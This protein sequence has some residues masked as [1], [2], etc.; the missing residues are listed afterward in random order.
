MGAVLVAAASA[1]QLAVALVE[2]AA[3]AL[4]HWRWNSSFAIFDHTLQHS[5]ILAAL[6]AWQDSVEG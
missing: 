5:V 6:V 1:T 4:R 2:A 3:L